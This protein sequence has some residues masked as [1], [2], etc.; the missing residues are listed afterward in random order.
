MDEERRAVLIHGDARDAL[1]DAVHDAIRL[2]GAGRCRRSGEWFWFFT[3]VGGAGRCPRWGSSAYL[4]ALVSAS[5]MKPRRLTAPRRVHDGI[6]ETRRGGVRGYRG[7]GA[8]GRCAAGVAGRT[9]CFDDDDDQFRQANFT[10]TGRARLRA[11]WSTIKRP[12]WRGSRRRG[13]RVEP[14]AARRNG[15]PPP[16][17]PPPH[18]ARP[19]QS[20]LGCPLPPT[21]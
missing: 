16:N 20:E 8:H 10:T 2:V 3:R 15:T 11:P 9:R 12:R 13:S 19:V 7:E 21:I 14:K 5:S 1:G 6:R 17:P 4:G 18:G